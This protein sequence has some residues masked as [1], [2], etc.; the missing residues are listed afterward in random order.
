MIGMRG[1]DEGDWGGVG[2]SGEGGVG[3]SGKMGRGLACEGEGGCE[4]CLGGS[5]GCI[6][7]WRYLIAL[8]TQGARPF[9]GR[10]DVYPIGETS[11]ERV[12][13]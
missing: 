11:E 2:Q 3:C 8:L 9:E 6:C 10:G 1:W 12:I 7:V 13:L 4:G 5:G